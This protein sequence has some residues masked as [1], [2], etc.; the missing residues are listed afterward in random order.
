MPA[1]KEFLMIGGK[2]KSFFLQNLLRMS[3]TKHEIIQATKKT[4][5]RLMLKPAFLMKLESKDVSL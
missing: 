2:R 1:S 4:K 3:T 5:K